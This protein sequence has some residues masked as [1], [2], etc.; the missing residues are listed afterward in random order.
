MDSK[1]IG[2]HWIIVSWR[3]E[4]DDGRVVLPL[5]DD[6][7]G[8]VQYH[9]GRVVVMLIDATRPNFTTSGQWG[10]SIMRSAR[11]EIF[12]PAPA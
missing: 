1:D 6:L 11:E 9:D 3:Q 12:G 8:F 5:G 7:T 4:Y 10:A 2:R